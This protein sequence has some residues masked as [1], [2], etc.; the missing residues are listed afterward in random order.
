MS[1]ERINSIIASNYSTT[2][3]LDYLG[4]KIRVTFTGSCLK[5]DKI[6]YTHGKIVNIYIVCGIIRNYNISSYPTIENCLFGAISLTKN[7]DIDKY[8][9]SGYRFDRKAKFSVGNGF[10]RNF[11][12]LGVDMSSLVHVNNKK[13]IF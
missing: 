9:Y 8:K 1:D 5:Q 12:I 13:K 11:I 4:G 2:P 6:T 3:S 7:G 10:G